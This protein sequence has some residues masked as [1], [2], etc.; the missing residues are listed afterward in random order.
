MIKVKAK[1]MRASA[2]LPVF[3]WR[4]IWNAAVYL[5]NRTPIQ[6]LVNF[7]TPH[8]RFHTFF[9]RQRGLVAENKKPLLSHLKAY[10]CMVYALTV[11]YRLGRLRREKLKEEC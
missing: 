7:M 1:A 5:Y 2:R 11:D 8:E 9:S 3:L 4:H 6:Y 10:G